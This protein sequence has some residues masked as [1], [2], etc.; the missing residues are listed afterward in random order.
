MH[1]CNYVNVYYILMRIFTVLNLVSVW[2][3]YPQN[4][5]SGIY[6]NGNTLLKF[7][8][9]ALQAILEDVKAE[10][11]KVAQIVMDHDTPGGNIA[12]D[13]FPKVRITYCGN[14]T[15]RTLYPDLTKIKSIPCKVNFYMPKTACL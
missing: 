13:I 9:P 5:A 1:S 6:Y 10:G 14:H 15:A 2:G 3:L 4:P 8:N 7:L 11:F 12:C